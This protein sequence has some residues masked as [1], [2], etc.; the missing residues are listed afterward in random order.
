MNAQWVLFVYSMLHL[1]IYRVVHRH[2]IQ[3][4]FGK[5]YCYKIHVERGGTKSMY[6]TCSGGNVITH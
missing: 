2:N 6:K 3:C 4:C 1:A 5:I